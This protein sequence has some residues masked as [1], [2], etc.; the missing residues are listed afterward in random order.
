[1]GRLELMKSFCCKVEWS[2]PN[3]FDGRLYKGDDFKEALYACVWI[4][5]AFVFLGYVFTWVNVYAHEYMRM[6]VN[7][8]E[9][10]CIKRST[11]VWFVTLL[12]SSSVFRWHNSNR[13]WLF[14]FSFLFFSPFFLIPRNNIIMKL[15]N[16]SCSSNSQSG[17]C[18][19][20]QPAS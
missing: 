16:K 11:N 5:W 20:G 19:A 4:D 1:M 2:N 10:M 6:Y 14:Y 3:V 8:A 12:C 7:L 17:G 13:K 15:C 18:I 9:C